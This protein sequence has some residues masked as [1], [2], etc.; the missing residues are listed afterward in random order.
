VTTSWFAWVRSF[1]QE[2]LWSNE[3]LHP[4]PLAWLR[5]F[6]QLSVIIG[7]GFVR[8]QLL[9]R[10]NALTYLT[11]LALI[12]LLAVAVTMSNA[13]GISAENM[14]RVILEQVAAGSPEAVDNILPFVENL[15]FAALGT[16]GAV[17][18]L[19]T[20]VLAL[21]NVEKALNQIWG[22]KQQRS[23]ERRIPDYLAVLVVSPI[24]LG[25]ALSLGGTLQSQSLVQRLLE[26]PLF[27]TLYDVGLRQAPLLLLILAFSFIYW[28]LPNT[29]VRVVSA[30]LGGA[31]A[32]VL[33]ALAMYVYLS[34]NVGVLRYNTIFGSFA[35]LPLL[36]VW[37]YLGWA[38]ILLGAEV[39]YAHQTLP[40]YRR[41]VRGKPAGAAARESIGLAIAVELARAFRDGRPPWSVDALSD[42]LDIP[43][44]T[45][46]DVTGELERA[47]IL[48][49]CAGESVGGY[50][51]GRP[52]ERIDVEDVL[53]AMR[54]SRAAA[55]GDSEVARVV[56]QVLGE[57]DHGAAQA[58]EARNLRDLVEEL[59]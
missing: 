32:G 33:Y 39:A 6:V 35:F 41:E 29:R 2:S 15:N 55:I 25:L 22:M 10:A 44:R 57:V 17:L 14:T 1:L 11:L 38:I 3:P 46:R 19:L 18:F 58:A 20:T 21:G 40:L 34:F 5:G 9:L 43:L 27:A 24:L 37:M 48:V 45:V 53:T 49:P 51:I 50:Q 54:G 31:V 12:P 28:F 23:W 26:V 52:L 56:A 4:A 16:S 13:F 47:G 30:L 36:M 7:E 42:F 59:G 8:D